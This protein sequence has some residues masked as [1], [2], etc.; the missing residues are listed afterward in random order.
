MK[1][2][3]LPSSPFFKG[4]TPQQ[5]KVEFGNDLRDARVAEIVNGGKNVENALR[6]F[7]LPGIP[8][9][10]VESRDVFVAQPVQTAPVASRIPDAKFVEVT[11]VSDTYQTIPTANNIPEAKLTETVAAPN[12]YQSEEVSLAIQQ[13]TDPIADARANLDKIWDNK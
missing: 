6:K 1:T 13:T 8:K 7:N 3:I 2:S 9:N 10:I 5:K 11:P 4:E 12:K